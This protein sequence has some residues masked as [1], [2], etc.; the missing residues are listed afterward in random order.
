MN[1]LDVYPLTR[2]GVLRKFN[3]NDSFARR[4]EREATLSGSQLSVNRLVW[5]SQGTL[6]LSGSDDRKLALFPFPDYDRPSLSIDTPH[7]ASIF[8]VRFLPQSNDEVLISCAMDGTVYTH[9]L[10]SSPSLQLQLETTPITAVDEADE[11]TVPVCVKAQSRSELL[12]SHGGRVKDIE[13][14]E[15][16]PFLVWSAGEDG[17]VRQSDLRES[18]TD[19][20]SPNVL[21]NVRYPS[22]TRK[23]ELKA[24]DINKVQPHQIA[25]ACGDAY[26]RLYDRRM[27]SLGSSNTHYPDALM[28]LAPPHMTRYTEKHNCYLT[29]VS[30]AN[31]GDKVVCMYNLDHCY[32]FD[33]T[34]E[35]TTACTYYRPN[36]YES[37]NL[38]RTNHCT[39][40]GHGTYNPLMKLIKA[41]SDRTDKVSKMDTIWSVTEAIFRDPGNVGFYVTRAGLYLERR[42]HGDGSFALRDCDQAL[43][44]DPECREAHFLRCKALQ[45]CS[46]PSTALTF[47]YKFIDQFPDENKTQRVMELEEGL[48]E[49]L[50]SKQGL[51]DDQASSIKSTDE[52]EEE[53]FERRW[54]AEEIQEDAWFKYYHGRD[55]LEENSESKAFHQG[56]NPGGIWWNCQGGKRLLNQFVGQINSKKDFKECI[57]LGQ[58]DTHIA[59]GS[60]DGKLYIYKADSGQLINVFRADNRVVNCVQSHPTIT[61]LATSGTDSTVKLWSPGEVYADLEQ[62]ERV[63]EKNKTKL[64]SGPLMAS[65]IIAISHFFDDVDWIIRSDS[66]DEEDGDPQAHQCRL[67]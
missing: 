66:V 6:L 15:N 61:C 27:L 46:M 65:H 56:T 45:A 50:V 39:S 47:L 14:D 21:I 63:I 10:E 28:K 36:A 59:C 58:D 2:K 19:V 12:C 35:G 64:A 7:T 55:H 41:G 53:H 18:K 17:T 57:F 43:W 26:V 24:L 13:V 11:D 33:I 1:N 4:F 8:G 32:T 20:E 31:R 25:I 3:L 48:I 42:V 23:V 16:E 49:D 62:I 54:T 37:Q 52:E 67:A 51:V 5:N 30:F 34:S 44:L 29:S 40:G 9:R 38:P 60:D 22:G